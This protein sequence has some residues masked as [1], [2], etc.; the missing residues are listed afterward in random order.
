MML[1]NL[2]SILVRIIV[3]GVRWRDE[4]EWDRIG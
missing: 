3:L 1:V 4:K 2:M